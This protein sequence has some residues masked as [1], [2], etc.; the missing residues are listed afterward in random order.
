MMNGRKLCA[1]VPVKEA[2]DAKQRLASVLGPAERAQLAHAM[3]E[4]VLAALAAT[5]GIA[6]ML[7]VTADHKAAGIA[8]RFGAEVT[9]EQAQAGHTTAVSHAAARLTNRDLDMLALPA[10]IPLVQPDDIAHLLALH[11][12]AAGRG[13]PLFAIVPAR[14]ERGSNA[15]ICSP[16]TAVPLRFGEDSF[17]AHLAAARARGIEPAIARLPRI[18]LDIDRPDDLAAL[19]AADAPTRTHALLRSWRRDDLAALSAV[20]ARSM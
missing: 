15:V 2:G 17:I 13:T 12:Q 18:A 1:V 9:A 20:D 4:D 14:D 16:A 8:A 3:L 10:D 7:V 5:S 19:L 6:S 11:W